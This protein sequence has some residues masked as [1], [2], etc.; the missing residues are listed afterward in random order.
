MEYNIIDNSDDN[1]RLQTTRLLYRLL[2][3]CPKEKSYG[4]KTNIYKPPHH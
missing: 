2:R 4:K 3:V 1:S